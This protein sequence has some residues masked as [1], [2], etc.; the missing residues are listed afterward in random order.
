MKK[1]SSAAQALASKQVRRDRGKKI[2]AVLAGIAV[3]GIGAVSV[4]TISRLKQ[5]DTIL[6]AQNLVSQFE[7]NTTYREPELADDEDNDGDGLTNAE[8]KKLGTNPLDE[9]SDSDGVPDG[10]EVGLETDPLNPDTDGDTLLDGYELILGLDPKE[11]RS[12][13]ITRD[14]VR[15]MKYS[16]N[17]GQITVDMKGTA[18]IADVSVTELNLFGISSNTSIVSKAYDII[19]DYKFDYASVTFQVSKDRLQKQGIDMSD[20]SV[21]RFNPANQQYTKLEST[22]DVDKAVVK[23]NINTYGTYVVGVEG[24]VNKAPLTRIAFLLDNSGSMYPVEKCAVSPENDVNFKRLDFTRSLISKIEGAGDYQ[25]SIAKFTGNY[26]LMQSFTTNT[27]KLNDA[28]KRIR[29]DEEVFDGSHIETALEKCMGS[30]DN[31]KSTNTRNIIVLLSDG[32]SD[33]IG[34]KSIAQL[35]KLADEKNIIIMTVGL[36]READRNWLQ[37]VSAETGGKYYSASDADALENVYHQ[38]VTTLNYDIVDYSESEEAAQGYSLYNT[39]FDPMKNGLS[40]KNFRAS[41]TPSLDYGIALLARDW[42]VGRLPMKLG[43]IKPFEESKQ[44]YEAKGYDFKGTDVEKRFNNHQPLSNLVP[45]LMS[46]ELAD[47]K[48]YLDYTS[49]GGTLRVKSELEKKAENQGWKVKEYK[50][51]A[52]NLHWNRVELLSLDIAGS[53]DKVRFSSSDWEAELYKAL[54]RL[55]AVQWADDG[56]TFDLRNGDEGFD[57]LKRLLAIGE[58]VV[59]MIDGSHTVNATGLIQDST[60]HRKYILTIYDN[61]YPGVEKK[62]YITKT[63][64][65]DFGISDGKNVD[66]RKVGAKYTCEYEGKQVGVEFS[67]IAV[68]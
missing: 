46:G 52:N 11:E 32:A 25:Y 23:A 45:K 42:Y 12:D 27:D 66:L 10:I 51:N 5:N 21:L 4:V 44:K 6:L 61:N 8:E 59:T 1:E 33:E 47:V 37:N 3:I 60:D 48:R 54:Y 62:L 67:D 26:K 58:P 40:V 15:L 53:E 43:G 2:A 24:S 31:T 17:E 65:G 68:Q 20:L 18:N 63:I 29:S 64:V 9:D 22:Y 56:A 7:I 28:L 57:N 38:I 41:K 49:M 16:V 34:A 30:F 39:G 13:G 55:N 19:S 50:L 14:V 35:A 36:G